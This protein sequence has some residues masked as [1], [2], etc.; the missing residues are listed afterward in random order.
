MIAAITWELI[1]AQTMETNGRKGL[2]TLHR[3]EAQRMGGILGT[4]FL[5]QP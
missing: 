5:Q 3:Q 4:R 1:A 2:A